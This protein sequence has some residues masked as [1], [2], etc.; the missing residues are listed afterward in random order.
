MSTGSLPEGAIP[1]GHDTFYTKV[2]K[3][4]EWVAIHE[5]HK[6]AGDDEYS[7]GFIAFAE[8]VKPDWWAGGPTWELLSEEP[9]TLSP[10]LACRNCGHHGFIREG[11]WV[12]A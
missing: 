3:D 9:L 10:S 5:W 2:Y 11:K 1:L 6:E 12:P 8:R 4:D 7:A